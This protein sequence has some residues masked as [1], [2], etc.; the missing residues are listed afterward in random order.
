[1]VFRVAADESITADGNATFLIGE[2][3][4]IRLESP[5]R[6]RIVDTPAGKQL[7]IPLD[8]PAGT[9]TFVLEYSW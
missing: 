2:S 6:A 5:Q 7:R 4:H 8:V 9:T 3:L 1:M